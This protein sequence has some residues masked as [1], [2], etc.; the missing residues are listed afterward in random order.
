LFLSILS[1][2]TTYIQL[3]LDKSRNKLE[4]K[5]KY[6]RAQLEKELDAIIS[7]DDDSSAKKK[8][9]Q[10]TSDERSKKIATVLAQTMYCLQPA[11]R[12]GISVFNLNSDN[13]LSETIFRSICKGKFDRIEYSRR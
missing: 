8:K 9:K 7:H 11:V 1:N 2:S 13:D 12:S 4:E 3:Q 6:H 5:F 10:T